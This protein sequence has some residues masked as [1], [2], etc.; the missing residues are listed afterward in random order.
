M[1]YPLALLCA[2]ALSGAAGAQTLQPVNIQFEYATDNQNELVAP[3]QAQPFYVMLKGSEILYHVSPFQC[4]GRV[5]VDVAKPITRPAVVLVTVKEAGECHI[6][7][8]TS[9]RRYQLWVTG[10]ESTPARPVPPIWTVRW[11]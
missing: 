9:M 3:V 8:Q 4:R 10:K 11:L 2:A 1:R 5:A 7:I 6:T